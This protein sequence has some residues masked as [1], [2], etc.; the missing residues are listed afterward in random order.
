[1]SLDLDLKPI[2]SFSFPEMREYILELCESVTCQ[3]ETWRVCQKNQAQ[4]EESVRTLC[5]VRKGETPASFRYLVTK[6]EATY[7]KVEEVA[8]GKDSD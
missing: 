2:A 1:M 6:D 4:R 3:R 5:G 7:K 8:M